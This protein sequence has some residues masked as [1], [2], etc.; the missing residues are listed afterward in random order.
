MRNLFVKLSFMTLLCY[1]LNFT[2][3]SMPQGFYRVTAVYTTF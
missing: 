1:L 2:G 3:E